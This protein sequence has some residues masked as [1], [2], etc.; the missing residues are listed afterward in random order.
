[1]MTVATLCQKTINNNFTVGQTITGSLQATDLGTTPLN[2]NSLI[3]GTVPDARLSANVQMKPVAQSDVANLVSDLAAK[4]NVSFV[5]SFE[6]DDYSEPGN[7][8][9]F[10]GVDGK[11]ITESWYPLT[12]LYDLANKTAP[13]VFT[14]GQEMPTLRLRNTASLPDQQA[15]HFA[16]DYYG[17]LHVKPITNAGGFRTGT[18]KL[19]G[20]L[21]LHNEPQLGTGNL[22]VAGTGAFMGTVTAAGLGTTPLNANNLTTGT[23]PDARLASNVARCALPNIFTAH[24]E[25]STAEAC[26]YIRDT[27]WDPNARLWQIAAS[28]GSLHFTA[29]TDAD[30]Y[31]AEVF[32]C[33]RDGTMSFYGPPSFYTDVK[34]LNAV[35]VGGVVQVGST[36]LP[37]VSWPAMRT[38]TPALGTSFANTAVQ[39]GAAKMASEMSRPT[40]R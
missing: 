33:N 13:N 14:A 31:Q 2:A 26:L 38:G 19:A 32:A 11:T 24:Q 7:L 4:G 15:W 21:D 3:S 6:G 1:M 37:N 16:V 23:V 8:V 22:T 28:Y 29:R 40:L 17:A 10:D 35:A 36:L 18:L 39:F 25:I 34:F 30:A 20:D 5:N 12:Q 27:S 9:I